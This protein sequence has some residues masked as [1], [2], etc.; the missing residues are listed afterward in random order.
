MWAGDPQRLPAPAPVMDNGPPNHLERGCIDAPPQVIALLPHSTMPPFDLLRWTR[1]ATYAYLVAVPGL[2]ESLNLLAIHD[3]ARALQAALCCLAVAAWAQRFDPRQC[4]LSRLQLG[5]VG[6]MVALTL[7]SIVQAQ[8]PLFAATEACLWMGLIALGWVFAASDKDC[9]S[10]EIP[11]VIAAAVLAMAL[12]EVMNIGFAWLSH[13]P[14]DVG[15]VGRG[16]PNRRHFNHV[17]TMA[18][19]L[20][21]IPMWYGQA[22]WIRWSA[23]LGFVVGMALVWFSGARSTL[24]SLAIVSLGF[25][26]LVQQKHFWTKRLLL[27]V[28]ASVATYIIVYRWTPDAIGVV[29]ADAETMS[30]RNQAGTVNT[31]IML[32]Q[33]AWNMAAAKPWT[34]WGGLH[35][36]TLTHLPAAHPHNIILQWAAE[37]GW[38]STL[39]ALFALA[40]LTRLARAAMRRRLRGASW[41]LSPIATAAGLASLA[42]WVDAM[43]SGT[44]T[45]PASQVWWLFCLGTHQINKLAEIDSNSKEANSKKHLIGIV[46]TLLTLSIAN[47]TYNHLC[48]FDMQSNPRSESLQPRLWL[49]GNLPKQGS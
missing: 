20:A 42:G 49:L 43:F 15:D 46:F 1:Y 30:Q 27:M 19:I 4:R 17:Q 37:W 40:R 39:L 11:G 45:M 38:V 3:T 44:L 6:L 14:L 9:L 36:A 32:W 28:A 18:L 47:A 16:H 23:W 34:G 33:H 12:Q 26:A 41:P 2:V 22:R 48:G 13:F 10:Q 31:R 21:G 29:I 24:L 8:W 35:Y 25:L 5:L 7:V